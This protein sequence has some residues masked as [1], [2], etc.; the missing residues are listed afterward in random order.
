M[1]ARTLETIAKRHCVSDKK[2]QQK[3]RTRFKGNVSSMFM[4]GWGFVTTKI[5]LSEIT[6]FHQFQVHFCLSWRISL[7][8]EVGIKFNRR[9]TK[10][11]EIL[12]SLKSRRVDFFRLS[13]IFFF[14]SLFR[15]RARGPCRSCGRPGWSSCR[16]S[17]WRGWGSRLKRNTKIFG[18]F[19]ICM[20]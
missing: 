7:S 9:W 14:P 18:I 13:C 4:I 16:R 3:S 1:I 15:R 12:K 20:S 8:S 2:N 11:E 6:F 17:G 10:T 5:L 19:K